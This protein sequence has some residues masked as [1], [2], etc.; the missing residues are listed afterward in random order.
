MRTAL[1]GVDGL[2]VMILEVK[3]ER[4]LRTDDEL[5]P[6][7]NHRHIYRQSTT[8]RAFPENLR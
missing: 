1:A 4:H 2:L 7:D 8:P 3:D 5:I 6:V